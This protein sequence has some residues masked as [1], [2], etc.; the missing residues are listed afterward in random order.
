L[1]KI[2]KKF[3]PEGATLDK[4]IVS[5]SGAVGK[6]EHVFLDSCYFY[7]QNGGDFMA[8]R[9][10]Y[11]KLP[12]G[13]GQIRYL[14]KGRRNPYGVYPPATEVDDI[15]RPK[16]PKALCYVPDW[17]TGFMVLTSYRA[18]NYL[19]G[20]ERNIDVKPGES[21]DLSSVVQ[22]LLSD[23]NQSQGIVEEKEE[24]GKTFRDVFELY[25]EDKFKVQYGHAGKKK[26]MEY[27]M[28]AAFK[29]SSALHDRDF[30]SLRLVD[31]QGV[32]NDCE[33][34]HSS[35][36]LIITL[37][38]QMYD[39]A[40]A[41]DICEK[42]YSQYVK[43]EIPD[44]D[45]HG[46]PFTDE[47]LAILWQNKHD[48]IVGM[49]LI[50]CYSGFRISAYRDMEVNLNEMY[51]HG[52]V[53]TDAGKERMVPIH[54]CIQDLV[55]Q[56]IVSYG[57]MLKGSP[58]YFRQ[59]MYDKLES[60]GIEK[61]TPHDCRHTFS[62][63]CEKYKVNENDRKRMLGHS[64]GNDITNRIYG[65]RTLEDLREEIEKIQPAVSDLL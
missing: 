28:G 22:K 8:K 15:G 27:S 19:P 4:H 2:L 65:H 64:F 25:Y 42:D 36:E 11:P 3:A 32:I 43:I 10:K 12:N 41:H 1:E 23:Y 58:D 48:P 44:D 49:I 17:M 33:L 63:L 40:V 59:P 34:K 31:L 56:R 52:G 38:H 21:T 47:E 6:S 20:D 7:T 60:L 61:H 50:M 16:T 57:T 24:P 39:F 13:Y 46:I 29:N 53:K 51:F 62:R 54:S 26:Q 18:G 35:L 45:E 55:K 30:V 5:S 37:F 14:G 9:K